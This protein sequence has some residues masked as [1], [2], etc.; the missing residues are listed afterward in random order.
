MTTRFIRVCGHKRDLRENGLFEYLRNTR[1]TRQ[2]GITYC[3]RRYHVQFFCRRSL[4]FYRLLHPHII[5]EASRLWSA[6]R[7]CAKVRACAPFRSHVSRDLLIPQT[8]T[9]ICGRS[10]IS[11]AFCV[12]TSLIQLSSI[13]SR[14]QRFIFIFLT[15]YFI[16][17]ILTIY[18]IFIFLTISFILIFLT[19]YTFVIVFN[20]YLKHLTRRI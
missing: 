20:F 1:V 7:L 10:T 18:F 8:L 11:P 6:E 15:I 3:R 14:T 13:L 19:I 12:Y 2:K 17:I 5:T 9:R 4:P 16:F